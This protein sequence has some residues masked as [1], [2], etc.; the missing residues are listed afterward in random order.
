MSIPTE[1]T[2]TA[3]LIGD[4][5][6][7]IS[8]ASTTEASEG[9]NG[10]TIAVVVGATAKTATTK[11]K[12]ELEEEEKRR[13][14][15]IETPIGVTSKFWKYFKVYPKANSFDGCV[16][17]ICHEKYKNDMTVSPTIW[18]VMYGNG[19]NIFKQGHKSPGKLEGHM[20]A[21]HFQLL[22]KM[23]EVDVHEKLN[24]LSNGENPKIIGPMNKFAKSS[25]SFKEANYMY[26]CLKL[27]ARNY[28][29]FSLIENPEFRK[30]MDCVSDGKVKHISAAYMKQKMH[31]KVIETNF[32]IKKMLE[33]QH[34]AFTTDTWTSD[35]NE[36]Y[37]AFVAHWVN[38][39]FELQSTCLNCSHFPGSHTADLVAKKII[40]SVEK[41]D[42]YPSK[43]ACI[44]TDN[45]ATM[46]CMANQLPYN[47]MGCFD[48]LLE[49]ITGV[50][51]NSDKQIMTNARALISH[52]NHSSQA[53]G[54]LKA[55]QSSLY[56]DQQPITLIQDVS[57]RWWS[58]WLMCERLIKLETCLDTLHRVGDIPLKLSDAEWSHLKHVIKILGSFT[59]V[60][61]LMEG[62]N[63]VT[64]SCIPIAV[65]CLRSHLTARLEEYTAMNQPVFVDCLKKMLTLFNIRFGEGTPGTVLKEHLT[66]GHR[67]IR[68]GI[69]YVAL[70]SCAI[71]P[72]TK[73]LGGIP[74]EE[75]SNLWDMVRKAMKD[76]YFETYEPNL[77][78]V[79]EESTSNANAI[80]D[81]SGEFGIFAQLKHFD[82]YYDDL[83]TIP[84]SAVSAFAS[85]P[86]S[87]VI[88]SGTTEADIAVEEELLHYIRKVSRKDYYVVQTKEEVVIFDPLK[89]YQQNENRFPL[90]SKLAR[91]FL[92]IPATSAS[93][94]RVFSCAGNVVT[95]KRNR[96]NVE[97]VEALVVLHKTWD[98]T[99]K[100]LSKSVK[101]NL[102]REENDNE[103][104]EDNKTRNKK[105]KTK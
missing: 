33:G 45:E 94:E 10:S 37:A 17:T 15:P 50:M 85:S 43:V 61:K 8:I 100:F 23:K 80:E 55:L 71:D 83:S 53:E 38:D 70:I 77:R 96:L 69:P 90:L 81:D 21:K 46:N 4:S 48:H 86:A 16:C 68:K 98:L 87:N 31:E 2:L 51:F 52:F 9:G 67:Q 84:S 44:V 12:E 91:R 32:G 60:E 56:P 40:E 78:P 20:K 27:I 103:E 89:W 26:Y 97:N 92:C 25:Y 24:S 93:S 41:Y 1:I 49:T 3:P 30:L 82:E 63:Y 58:T 34:V 14:W 36:S 7:A 57:T 65:F 99:E 72:R 66:R 105:L 62:E 95:S 47:W 13:S 22:M 39:D 59:V 28:L 42:I 54:K 102:F 64:I 19:S 35:C 11:T 73:N 88:N 74:I 104:G 18:E 5:S 6:V 79:G 76:V 75:H 101:V 29:P